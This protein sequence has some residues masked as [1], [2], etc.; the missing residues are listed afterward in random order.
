MAWLSHRA[1][2]RVAS[3]ARLDVAGAIW[4]GGGATLVVDGEARVA[5]RAERAGSGGRPA[6][7]AAPGHP[8]TAM[9]DPP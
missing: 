3:G 4:L 2:I 7:A 6:A 8:G 9:R 5:A 1:G